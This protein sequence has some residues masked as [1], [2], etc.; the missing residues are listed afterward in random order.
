MLVG[1]KQNY[2]NVNFWRKRSAEDGKIDWRMSAKNIS[3]LVKAL[4]K[5]YLGAHFL[6]NRKKIILSKFL[7]VKVKNRNIEPGKVISF[8]KSKPVV[9]CGEDAICMLKTYPKI[10]V[11][12]GNYL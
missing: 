12:V 5:P 9:K 3:N 8:L 11:K 7:L 6:L 1:I 2:K 4:S 10:K